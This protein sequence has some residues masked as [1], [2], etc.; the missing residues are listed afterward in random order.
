M[1]GRFG[2]ALERELNAVLDVVLEKQVSVSK[3]FSRARE[4]AMSVSVADSGL[5]DA[6][7]VK[8]AKD[9][10]KAAGAHIASSSDKI[11]CLTWHNRPEFDCQHT[12]VLAP[13]GY[14]GETLAKW[15][16]GER[17]FIW[18]PWVIK[19]Y[20]RYSVDQQKVEVAA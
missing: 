18:G 9:I 14:Q 6:A 10:A 1:D 7:A 4:F 12:M 2:V 13:P 20:M 19:F 3:P 8:A 16:E 11:K 5:T 17:P 15:R